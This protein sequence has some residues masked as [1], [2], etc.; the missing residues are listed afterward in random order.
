MYMGVATGPFGQIR[1]Y[2]HAGTRRYLVLDSHGYT[3]RFRRGR[4]GLRLEPVEL[5]DAVSG[6]LS[7]P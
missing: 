2:K 6:V 4:F 1:L 5:A 7:S 3:Y